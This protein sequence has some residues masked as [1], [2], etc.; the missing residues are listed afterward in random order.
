MSLHIRWMIRRD[1]PEVLQIEKASFEDGWKEEDFLVALRQV[2]CIGNVAEIGE[3][4]VGFFLWEMQQGFLKITNF[5]IDPNYRRQGIGKAM[6]QKLFTKL[7][8][9]RNRITMMVKESNLP[10]QLFFKTMGFECTGIKKRFYREENEDGY[11]FQ[12]VI[13]MGIPMEPVLESSE[14]L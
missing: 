6:I 13:P 12:I 7:Q 4:I 3:K 8:E 9:N 14:S 1:L 11:L 2:N 5:A 10:A